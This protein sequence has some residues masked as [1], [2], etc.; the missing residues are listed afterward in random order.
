MIGGEKISLH[1]E[2]DEEISEISI[3][4]VLAALLEHNEHAYNQFH[5]LSHEHKLRVIQNIKGANEMDEQI[6]ISLKLLSKSGS[7]D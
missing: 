1:L 3:P 7:K 4:A 2:T 6:D 5:Q